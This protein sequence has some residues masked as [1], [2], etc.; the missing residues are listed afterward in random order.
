MNKRFSFSIKVKLIIMFVIAIVVTAWSI[1]SLLILAQYNNMLEQI[2]VDSI[3]MAKIYA[4]AVENV[5][6]TSGDINVVQKMVEKIAKSD[7]MLYGGLV[8]KNFVAVC[9]G[10]P[11]GIGVKYDNDPNTRKAVIDKQIS[12]AIWTNPADNSKALD[13]QIPVDFT[14]GSNQIATVDLGIDLKGLYDARQKALLQCAVVVAIVVAIILILYYIL[15][16]VF[17]IK[18]LKEGMRIAESIA[19]GDLTVT[20]T[21]N[22]KDEMGM[23]LLSVLKAKDNLKRI[24]A[25]IR[26]SSTSVMSASEQLNKSI[27][28]VNR[29][30]ENINSGVTN[31]TADFESN[32]ATVKQTS[33]AVANVAGNSQKAAESASNVSQYTKSVKE[34]AINGRKSVEDIV[35]IINEIS[36]SSNNVQTVI[37]K[38]EESTLKIGDIVN[39]I[40]EISD[41]TNLLALNAAIEAA[42]AGESGKGFAVVA[43]EVR[44]LAEQ[45]R[46]AL[47]GIVELIKDI[48]TKTENVVAVS[49]TTREKVQMGVS[50]AEVTKTNINEIIESIQ[51]V[52]QRVTDISSIAAEQAAAMQQMNT[53]MAGIND[54]INKGAET[55][56]SINVNV[57]EETNAFEEINI[58][59]AELKKMSENLGKLIEQFKL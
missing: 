13:V 58:T 53:A 34:S 55:S 19:S 45:S 9:D 7:G 30:I 24:I 33:I 25:Q 5:N 27:Y 12:T 15:I 57:H 41:Q 37:K 20:S 59:A 10:D 46:E 3:N 47:N 51:N 6:E 21:V 32:S 42:R 14:M 40:S 31:L 28:D 56:Q 49:L 50:K 8:D 38:L 36:D 16:R 2:K 18:P 29:V 17:F 22:K 43:D 39:I 44:R 11:A 35:D 52:I 1:A 54:S 23:I 48:Q 26:Q 4:L